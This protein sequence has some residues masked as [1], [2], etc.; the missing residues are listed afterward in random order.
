MNKQP[1]VHWKKVHLALKIIRTL[2]M[3]VYNDTIHEIFTSV[4]KHSKNPFCDQSFF[5]HTSDFKDFFFTLWY[6][7]EKRYKIEASKI[8]PVLKICT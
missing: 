2:K 1:L 8:D 7:I 4:K 3:K 5:K 6:T